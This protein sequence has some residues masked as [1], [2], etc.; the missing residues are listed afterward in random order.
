[1]SGGRDGIGEGRVEAPAA[2]TA[3]VGLH[4]ELS[5]SLRRLRDLLEEDARRRSPEA[6]SEVV[7]RARARLV[8]DLLPRTV[9]G[10]P[11]LVAGIV[12][13]N[14]SG[15]SALF[16][17][18]VGRELS[19]SLPTGGATRRLYGA[20][21][22][23]LAERLFRDPTLERFAIVAAGTLSA[24]ERTAA[25]APAPDP[26]ELLLF[27]AELPDALLL[28]DTPDFDSVLEENR[29]ASESL[30]AVADL[31]IAVVTRHTYQNREVVHFLLRWL[32]HGRPWLLVYNEAPSPEIAREHAHKLASDLGHEPLAIFAA[33]HSLAVQ[34]GSARLTPTRIDRT[35][36]GAPE[37]LS[38]FLFDVERVGEVKARALSASLAQL[39]DDLAE[40]RGLLEAEAQN[41][42]TLLE[43]AEGHA[44]GAALR[45]GSCAMPGGPF[46]EAFRA[47]LD[48]RSNPL[49]R[50]WRMG[51]RK[52]RLK[53]EAL[54]S[55]FA[56]RRVPAPDAVR[57]SLADVEGA[58][59]ERAWPAFWEELV[60]DLGP[61]G[62]AGARGAIAGVIRD[63]LDRDLA[64]ARGRSARSTASASLASSSMDLEAFQLFCEVLVEDAIRER[65]RD[66]D[67]QAAVDVA[68]IAPIAIAAA[69]IIKTGGLGSDVGVAGGAALS[70]YLFEKYSHLLGTRITNEAARRWAAQRSAEVLP[71]LVSSVLAESAAL[72]R[73]TIQ[74]SRTLSAEVAVLARQVV[75]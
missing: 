68:M 56:A 53:L 12:G 60:R 1:M 44:R 36:N 55:L 64:E 42:Q 67:I 48:R 52:V 13:P 26:A 41:A 49:T 65:G 40:W 24:E 62:R 23:E 19:P 15:K 73:D 50:S 71:V 70:S 74:R 58:E 51:L 75:P 8:R 29:L 43:A 20:A 38:G 45:I 16:N 61:E 69:V 6:D 11:Y 35:T 63:A 18:I 66:W 47:V 34:E 4:P 37:D 25:A 31:A 57:Q 5:A 27:P 54:P 7:A 39:A 9:G 30:L 72:L 21:H 22:P 3:R 14:N 17:S 33:P 46:I 59:L 10:A 28:I 32:S 2:G